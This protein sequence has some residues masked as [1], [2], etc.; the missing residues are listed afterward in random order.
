YAE[1]GQ[2]AIAQE[3]QHRAVIAEDR[4]DDDL[5]VAVEDLHHALGLAPLGKPREAIDVDEE[6]RSERA[7]TAERAAVRCFHDARD[8]SLADVL[9]EQL[10]L[11]VV[12]NRVFNRLDER[13]CVEEGPTDGEQR[14]ARDDELSEC[15]R[16]PTVNHG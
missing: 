13:W 3:L 5:Q 16:P 8:E 7:L 9:R 14:P 10:A 15:R 11:I 4:I 2:D 6:D 1:R 12:P